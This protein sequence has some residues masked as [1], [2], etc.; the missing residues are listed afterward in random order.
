MARLGQAEITIVDVSD[1]LTG[2]DGSSNAVVSLYKNHTSSSTA[3][4][5][6]TG[7][8]TYTFA[9]GV[10]SG[11]TLAGWSQSPPT[12]ATG[13]YLWVRQAVASSNTATDTIAISEW[14]TATVVGYSGVNGLNSKPI[15]LYAINSSTTAPTA[16]T[17]TATYTFS[18][19]ALTGLTL[20]TWSRTANSLSKGNYLW[21]RSAIA[22]STTDTD[23]IAIGEWSTAAI[24]G[25]GGVDGATGATGA[26]GA[27]GARGAGWWRY[28]AGAA[29]LSG[30]DTTSEVNVY[31]NALHN[32]DILVVK[33][34][35]FIIAT[36]HASGT[37]AFIYDGT[38][39]ISQA[40]FV[41]GNLLVDGTVTATKISVN[42]LSAISGTLGTFQ[43]AATG[44]RVV[45]Q[46]DTIRV[47]DANNILRVVIGDLT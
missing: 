31:W 5:S 7:T 43:S 10:V 32:P 34:D 28:D 2:P 30:V 8:A 46:T 37:K 9:T 27:T 6:F 26:V 11:L 40:A 23:T 14:S 15:F 42:E 35:R 47:Y 4:T 41:D 36:T 29:D 24:V 21:M 33:D 38:N 45:I 19:D 16:F 39:W 17:G 20:G 13:E 22:T 3:P 12:L 44:E 1:G 18:T 25:I